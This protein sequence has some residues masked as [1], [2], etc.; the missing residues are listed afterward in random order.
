MKTKQTAQSAFLNLSILT[1]LAVFFVGL[2]LA[3][4]ATA[5][6]QTSMRMRTHNLNAHVSA[7][8]PGA[9]PTATPCASVGTWTKQAPYPISIIGA[10]VAAQGD[11]IYTFGGLPNGIPTTA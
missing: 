4:L 1:G 5:K 7:G 8:A 6:P 10:G 9:T 2:L 3:L 11:N